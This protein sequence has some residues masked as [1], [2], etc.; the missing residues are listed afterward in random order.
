MNYNIDI[1]AGF[2][3]T[4]PPPCLTVKTNFLYLPQNVSKLSKIKSWIC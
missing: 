2:I 3:I 1:P 4:E